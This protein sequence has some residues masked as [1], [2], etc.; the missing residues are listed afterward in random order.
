MNCEAKGKITAVF[1]AEGKGAKQQVW[2]KTIKK[3]AP[4][5]P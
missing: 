4:R 1:Y 3:A 5:P 2:V